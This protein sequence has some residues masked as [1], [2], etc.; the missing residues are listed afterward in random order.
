V[1]VLVSFDL[2]GIATELIDC[3][4][5]ARCRVRCGK[6]GWVAEEEATECGDGIGNV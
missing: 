4:V 6:G 5:R 3:G 1:K 2:V